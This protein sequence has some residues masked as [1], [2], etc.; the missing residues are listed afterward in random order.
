MTT[1]NEV[2]TVKKSK[3]ELMKI[4]AKKHLRGIFPTVIGRDI[5]IDI[6]TG[7]K[8][9]RE[10]FLN[11][12]EG[13]TDFDTFNEV[14]RLLNHKKFLMIEHPVTRPS[15]DGAIVNVGKHFVAYNIGNDYGK[16]LWENLK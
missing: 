3:S 12:I 4:I 14:E 11:R 9:D 5:L 8:V 6:S 2:S 10:Q 1:A 7:I 13:K 15:E 16:L